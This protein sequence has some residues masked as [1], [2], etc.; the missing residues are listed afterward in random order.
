MTRYTNIG[1]K[2]KY[3]EA[4]FDND[5][6]DVEPTSQVCS[7]AVEDGTTNAPQDSGVV[8]TPRKK[9]KR[10][11]KPKT[12]NVDVEGAQ[13]TKRDEAEGKEGADEQNKEGTKGTSGK[14]EKK[15][16]EKDKERKKFGAK[17]RSEQRRQ[18]R[19][20]ERHANTTCLAC[21]EKGHM[22]KDCPKGEA[23]GQ[24]GGKAAQRKSIV[25]ICYRCGS[26]RHNLSRCKKAVDPGSPLPFASCFV[27]SGTGHL[28]SAC[29]QNKEKGIYPNGGSCK[30]CGETTHLAK[31]CTLR[32]N[33]ATKNGSAPLIGTGHQVGA[34]EDDF[35]IF[36]RRTAEIELEEKQAEKARRLANVKVGVHSGAVR[37]FG[38][39]AP[40]QK[41]IVLF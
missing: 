22:A 40:A 41:K 24:Q 13:G 8:D 7:H 30:L 5:A 14:Q 9:R 2:R 27:C 17:A 31:N 10:N 23:E 18:K 35:H 6:D 29:P 25:G 16:G 34:D 19:V 3:L 36:K 26:R 12:G 37:A 20:N 21:R 39:A 1:Y 38:K 4:G 11:R 33:D 15:K 32:Q 28:A